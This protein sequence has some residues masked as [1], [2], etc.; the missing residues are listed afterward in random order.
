MPLLSVFVVCS[1]ECIFRV[2]CFAISSATV[3]CYAYWCLLLVEACCNVVVCCS[4]IFVLLYPS[5]V[6]CGM[7]FGIYGT[8][9]FSSVLAN[10]ERSE[11]NEHHSI[12]FFANMSLKKH[13][14]IYV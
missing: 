6:I 7:V 14:H 3:N 2:T 9:V 13:T 12:V 1:S 8:M 11:M 10:V 5:C 4:F